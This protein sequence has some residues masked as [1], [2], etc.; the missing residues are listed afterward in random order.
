RCSFT[1]IWVDHFNGGGSPAPLLLLAGCAALATTVATLF[2]IAAKWRATR[3][4]LPWSG[5][6][7]YL[8]TLYLWLLA[9]HWNALWLLV[10]PTLHSL[11]YLLVVARYRINRVRDAED[12]AGVPAGEPLLARLFGRRDRQRLVGF[13]AL[14]VLLGYVGFIG[15]PELLGPFVPYDRSVFGPN[16]M[17]F[18]LWIF[19]NV[20][21]YF[22]DNVMWRSRNADMRKYLFG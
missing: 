5:I 22:L 3:G 6:A 17:L 11:Q 20:H 13:A 1:Y 16:A 2:V 15:A 14:G 8:V 21:H 12:A 4:R 18:V 19:I 9:M 10:V 7:A